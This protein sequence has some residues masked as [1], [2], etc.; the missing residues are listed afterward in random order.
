[1][2]SNQN[3]EI[4]LQKLFQQKK[5]SEIVYE[6]VTNTDEKDRSASLSNLLGISRITNNRDNKEI[7]SLALNDFKKLF[8]L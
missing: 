6:I 4:Q 5:Y 2:V 8:Q 3:L 1:M 7:V